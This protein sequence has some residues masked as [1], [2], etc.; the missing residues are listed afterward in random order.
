MVCIHQ[1]C[2]N[3]IMVGTYFIGCVALLETQIPYIYSPKKVKDI[4]IFGGIFY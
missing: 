1:N 3:E 2:I 4:I